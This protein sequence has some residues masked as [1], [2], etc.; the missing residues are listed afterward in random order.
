VIPRTSVPV[1]G[2]LAG[3]ALTL[4]RGIGLLSMYRKMIQ[5]VVPLAKRTRV[6]SW[7]H[8]RYELHFQDFQASGTSLGSSGSGT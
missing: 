5:R 6:S 8:N 7:S 4:L 2:S 1:K 3:T